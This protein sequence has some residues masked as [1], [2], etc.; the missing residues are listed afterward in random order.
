MDSL[1]AQIYEEHHRTNRCYL[2]LTKVRNS[3][4]RLPK[5]II[6]VL[7]LVQINQLGFGF[8]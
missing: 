2:S 1:D 5:F 8:K 6:C 4:L 3:V 7:E